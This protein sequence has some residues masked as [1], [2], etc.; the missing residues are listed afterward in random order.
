MKRKLVIALCVCACVLT[1]CGKDK[2]SVEITV[3]KPVI[4]DVSEQV[5]EEPVEEQLDE[6]LA[7][8]LDEEASVTQTNTVSKFFKSRERVWFF[9]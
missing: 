2:K 4:E 5:A 3:E 7:E 9:C 6:E 1:A 8:D